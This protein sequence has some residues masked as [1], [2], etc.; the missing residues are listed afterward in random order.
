MP[1]KR[2]S[3]A[4]IV[5]FL[6]SF[7]G[8]VHAE[9]PVAS[10][11]FPAGGQRGKTVDFKVG[12]L[13][14]SKSCAFEMLGAGL[15]ASPRL[16]RT[17]TVWFEGPFI[18]LPDSQQA[19]DYPK[20][21]AGQVRIEKDAPLGIRYWRLWNAQGATPAMKFMVGDLPEI[22]EQEIDGNAVPVEVSL[23]VT[24]NGRIFPREDVD[25][26]S[27]RAR[28][29]QSITAE[30]F[31][32]RL[33]S[34]LDSRLEVFDPHGRKIGENDD[35]LETDSRLRFIA[36][37]DGNYQVRIQDAGFR[38]G[39]AYVYRLTL[40][41]DPYVERIYP[42]GGRRGS[43][44]RF[45]L[46]GQGLPNDPV[47]TQLQATPSEN[48]WHRFSASGKLTNPVLL[49]LDD[50]PE[51]LETEPNDRPE[52]ARLLSL[53]AI[54]N[55]RIDKSGDVDYWAF[56]ARKSQ[57][58]EIDLR[59]RRLGSP[60]AGMLTVFDGKGK[61]L[62]NSE[63]VDSAADPF[64]RFTAPA[65][66]NYF[67]R[68][69]ER[70]HGRGGATFAYRLRL[71]QLGEP[72]FRVRPASDVLAVN[73]GSESKLKVLV[74]RM[75]SF[76]GPVSL[77]VEGLPKGV[78][79]ATTTIPAQQTAADISFRA[80]ATALLRGSRLTIR[81]SAVIGGRS[82]T[83]VATLAT[84]RGSP[85]LDS[86]LLVVT[87][88]TPFK[89]VG[90]FDMRW[91]PRG[92]VYHRRYRIER[93]GYEGALEVRLADRQMRHLQGVSGP[94]IIVPPGGNTFEF[95]VS[96]PPWMETGRTARA[97]VVAEGT[98]TDFDGSKHMVSFTS[99][100]QNEQ[101]I[102]V[103]E[104]GRLDIE[105]GR[106]SFLATPGKTLTIPVHV[107]RG[108]SLG[109]PVKVELV[110]PAH[111]RSLVADPIVVP[112]NQENG[113]L[114]IHFPAHLPGPFNAPV[115]LRATI[116]ERGEP[117]VAGTNVDIQPGP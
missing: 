85:E 20:D 28:K 11:I 35:S 103:V 59:A 86:V 39:Q 40:T 87:V 104:P 69:E 13:F 26:W 57:S 77:T 114:S 4:V 100:A 110:L 75:G 101:I 44:A 93:G 29:G 58:V 105:A 106:A 25:V 99:V 30:V 97:C 7:M 50:L 89:V 23:P 52:Q 17:D 94:E 3:C 33:G 79:A 38:G 37:E 14:L 55:G 90:D 112:A 2:N 63:A 46:T 64:L 6:C 73:R 36:A 102:A 70:F 62:A 41:A 96:L 51:Y 81:G 18:P 117:V 115:V 80:D 15:H 76:A 66:G 71:G 83:H 34:P 12:G 47:Q 107:T 67:V 68:V 21:L 109:G 78:T 82:T 10:Y 88:P 49:D 92:T 61:T 9:P 48:F 32:G 42:L 8:A 60:L 16:R 72:D 22:V 65:D 116:M 113:S 98:I 5:S 1:M 108:K 31:A 27:F 95:A 54:A 91:A 43:S 24:I 84:A 56:Q 45:E 111:L 19:E 53:P 74:E